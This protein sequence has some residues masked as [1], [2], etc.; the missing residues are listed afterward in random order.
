MNE[1]APRFDKWLWAARV[2]KTRTQAADACRLG[3]VTIGGQRVKPARDVVVGDV[4]A[5][6]QGE[7]TRTFKVLQWLGQRVG[8]ALVKDY[9]ED[10]TPA[11]EYEKR[12]EP[13]FQPI[14]FDRKGRGIRRKRSVFV[15]KLKSSSE[16]ARSA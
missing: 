16:G 14:A 4:V 13:D 3:R 2:F 1:T 5:V 9:C 12:R 11:A 7:I 6:R 10:L 15:R 8:A